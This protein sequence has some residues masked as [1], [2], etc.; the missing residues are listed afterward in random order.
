MVAEPLDRRA[1]WSPYRDHA[2][3]NEL[4]STDIP[5]KPPKSRLRKP[6]GVALGEV[7]DFFRWDGGQFCVP[8]ATV[9][10]MSTA[11]T[12]HC[13]L[14]PISIPNLEVYLANVVD[15]RIGVVDNRLSERRANSG[16]IVG[17]EFHAE[18]ITKPGLFRVPESKR[19]MLVATN[20]SDSRHHEDDFYGIYQALGL[21]GLR[22]KLLWSS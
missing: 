1:F 14:F 11:I 21:R 6:E 3:P 17:W 7:G 18:K 16:G 12:N 22:F 8:I 20:L 10:R 9:D 19:A 15:V 13:R 5:W 2:S 4:A